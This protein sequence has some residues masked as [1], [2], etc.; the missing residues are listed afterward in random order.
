MSDID[1]FA[2]DGN[3]DAIGK[4]L[5]SSDFQSIESAS[6]ILV[7]SDALSAD[8]KVQLCAIVSMSAHFM[9]GL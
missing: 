9:V 8:E 3:Y 5:A 2:K 7:R 1:A 4:I 6:T